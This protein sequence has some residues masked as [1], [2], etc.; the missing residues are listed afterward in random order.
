M[1][2]NVC[3]AEIH[4][5]VVEVYG[6]GACVERMWRNGVCCPKM[7][8]PMCKKSNEADA[9]FCHG[10]FERYGKC[11]NR[12]KQAIHN[13]WITRKLSSWTKSTR[14]GVYTKRSIMSRL[15]T[16][17]S[18]HGTEST[19]NSLQWADCTLNK[20]YTKHSTKSRLYTEQSLH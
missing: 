18:L 13:F 4:R 8:W 11:R 17:E 7:V 1:H 9:K 5:R 6:T 16:E 3:P 15:Y 20:V 10:K 19:L 12:V 14:N 2:Y